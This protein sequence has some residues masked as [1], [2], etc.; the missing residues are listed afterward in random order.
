M[1]TAWKSKLIA[2]PYVNQKNIL[3]IAEIIKIAQMSIEKVP[4]DF[5]Y[6]MSFS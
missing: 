6:L 5:C 1:K 4:R 2:K 3:S